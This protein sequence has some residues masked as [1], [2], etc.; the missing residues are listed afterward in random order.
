MSKKAAPKKRTTTKKTSAGS[1]LSAEQLALIEHQLLKERA[2]VLRSSAELQEMVDSG[3]LKMGGD[4]ADVS[5][6]WSSRENVSLLASREGERFR[7]IELTLARLQKNPDE[8]GLCE[9]C[10]EGIPFERL[11]LLPTTRTCQAHAV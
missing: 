9:T 7:T 3:E 6:S 4:F 5:S 2:R 1:H 11:E 10:G 8:F